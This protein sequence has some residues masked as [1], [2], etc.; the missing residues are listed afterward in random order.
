MLASR[1]RAAIGS[2]L[3]ILLVGAIVL[4]KLGSLVP[5]PTAAEQPA[6]LGI[7]EYESLLSDPFF[8]PERVIQA[9]LVYIDQAGG[10]SLR[11]ISVIFAAASLILLYWLL[12]M[13]HTRR[14]AFLSMLMLACSS[15]FLHQARWAEPDVMYMTA[16]PVFLIGAILL[17]KKRYDRLWPLTVFSLALLLYLPGMLALVGLFLIFNFGKIRKTFKYLAAPLRT[18]A[19]GMLIIPLIPLMYSFWQKPWLL[20]TWIGLP[21]NGL[22]IQ[23]VLRNLYEIPKQLF[24]SGPDDPLRWLSGT[25][26]LDAATIALVAIGI[27]SY[28]SGLYPVRWRVLAGL[29]LISVILISL[30][31][32]VSISLILPLVYIFTANGL[33][34]LLQQWFTVFPRNPFA[35]SVGII[36]VLIVV[37]AICGYHLTRYYL[38]WPHAPATYQALSD[39]A[40]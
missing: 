40:K 15:L 4:P 6:A 28:S 21:E 5:A 20:A 30:G 19:V 26:I 31:G 37:A 16:I 22:T 11:M 29:S 39:Q 8:L 38:A 1:W 33:A 9:G 10:T 34:L 23:S 13:W 36:V 7:T 12:S 14:I 24:V 35:R 25:P 27:Y 18:A 2:L 17:K 3:V 32:L